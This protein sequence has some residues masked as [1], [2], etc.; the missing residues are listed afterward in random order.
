M[1]E[2]KE[3]VRRHWDRRS[4]DFDLEAS[5]GLITDAQALAW[6]DLIARLAGAVPLDVLD[7]G[8]GTGFLSL[9]FAAQGHRVTGVDMAPRML[10]R[11][12]EKAAAEGLAVNFLECDVEAPDLPTA[13]YNLI[14]ER[15]V[16][17]T[18]PHPAAALDAWRQLLRRGGRL[19][20][21]EGH[22]GSDERR[23]E[24]NE[25][26]D[27]LPLFGGRPAA[28]MAALVRA[29]GFTPVSVEPLMNPEL[30]TESPSHPRYLVTAGA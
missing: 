26:H 4:T 16:I 17:W 23:D 10:V 25:I 3:L 30:W 27:R 22:W 15:H 14:V 28:E 24:Y 18:L 2:L 6:H 20:L 8:C 9:L 21:I 12:R 13:S 1:E 11:A 5:H 19:I 7:V 29:R